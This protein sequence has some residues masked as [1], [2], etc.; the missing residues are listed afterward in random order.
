MLA[1]FQTKI[2]VGILEEFLKD[3]DAVC[4]ILDLKS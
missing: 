2:A 1:A 3:S 4:K